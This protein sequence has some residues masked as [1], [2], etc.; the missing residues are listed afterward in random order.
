MMESDSVTA[1]FQL[2]QGNVQ[3][4]ASGNADAV[5]SEAEQRHREIMQSTIHT[6]GTQCRQAI[7]QMKK[8]CDEHVMSMQEDNIARKAIG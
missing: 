4:I 3:H 7:D 6:L 8:A 2:I 1:Y 5:R